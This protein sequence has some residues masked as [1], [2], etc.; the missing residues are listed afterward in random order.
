MLKNISAQRPAHGTSESGS[1]LIAV[2]VAV[3]MIL[4]VATVTMVEGLFNARHTDLSRK[5]IM[6]SEAAEAGMAAGILNLQQDDDNDG[7]TSGD[8]SDSAYAVTLDSKVG[9]TYTLTSAGV[10]QGVTKQI[11]SIAIRQSAVITPEDHPGAITAN[12]PVATL[13]TIEVD[14]RD[15][16]ENGN[17]TG[18]PGTYGISTTSTVSIGG[19]STVGGN[20]EAPGGAETGSNREENAVWPDGFPTSP[21]AYLGLPDGTLKAYAQA[22][23]TYFVTGATAQSWINNNVAQWAAGG[24]IFYLELP[25]GGKMQPVDWVVGLNTKPSLFI[26]HNATNDSIL[27]NLHGEFKGLVLSDYIT[28]INGTAMVVGGI[29]SFADDAVGNT[30]GTGNAEIL[31][32]ATVLS[33]LPSPEETPGGV[34][35]VSYQLLN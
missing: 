17:L 14:G 11:R 4:G 21:D 28:H 10:Y 8:I 31:F 19:S 27:K 16:D 18:A 2:L 7:S 32:S 1:A 33:Q 3:V 6:A 15:H 5:I 20:G 12:S 29:A 13:G 30:Y 25:S 9:D 24:V 26:C 23:G 22:Q 35:V 34:Q